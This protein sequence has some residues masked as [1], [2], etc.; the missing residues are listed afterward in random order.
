MG[1]LYYEP[2]IMAHDTIS[3]HR[4]VCR[5]AQEA[6]AQHQWVYR[7]EERKHNFHTS[8]AL[9]CLDETRQFLLWTHPPTSV[10]HTPNFKLA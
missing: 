3:R 8:V 2:T 7:Q 5:V 1:S 10:L 9:F 4:V 6:C